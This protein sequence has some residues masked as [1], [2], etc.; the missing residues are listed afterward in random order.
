MASPWNWLPPDFSTASSIM[1]RRGISAALPTVWTRVES[2]ALKSTWLPLAPPV[3]VVENITPSSICHDWPDWPYDLNC[4]VSLMSDAPTLRFVRTPGIVPMNAL[5]PSR[6]VGRI[7]SASDDMST[8]VAG[9]VTSTNGEAPDTVTDSETVPSPNDWSNV[10]VNPRA[11]RTP[12]R[13][14]VWN[15]GN[16]NVTVYEPGGNR[17]KRYS[18]LASLVDT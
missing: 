7:S 5:R 11:S 4:T 15:P 6:F 9:F 1:P 3:L 8:L 10:A 17:L 13:L 18:P 2:S 14:T 12:S 16:S